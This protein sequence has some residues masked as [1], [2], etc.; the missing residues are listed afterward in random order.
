MSNRQIRVLAIAP[1]I[2]RVHPT[3]ASASLGIMNKWEA[4]SPVVS[5]MTLAIT[6]ATPFAV[7]KAQ[8]W[9]ANETERWLNRLAIKACASTDHAYWGVAESSITAKNV[10]FQDRWWHATTAWWLPPKHLARVHNYVS[11]GQTLVSTKKC[12]RLPD[13]F[14][15]RQPIHAS[16][17]AIM[18]GTGMAIHAVAWRHTCR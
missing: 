7:H 17:M 18:A 15:T 12:V 8:C 10:A 14:S 1:H 13:Q 5:I 16:A 6:T 3:H 11:M 4:A 2:T 9:H